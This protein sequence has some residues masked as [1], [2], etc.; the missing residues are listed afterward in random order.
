MS[1]QSISLQETKDIAHLARL[2]FSDEELTHY[3]KDLERIV[4]LFKRLEEANLAMLS[5]NPAHK[6]QSVDDLRV[7]AVTESSVTEDEPELAHKTFP[8]FNKTTKQFD[9]PLV[10]DADEAS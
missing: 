1:D 4:A 7:D 2:A 10:I 6:I 9:V 5:P 3:T 8:H